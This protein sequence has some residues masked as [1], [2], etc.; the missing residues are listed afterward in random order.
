MLTRLRPN[1]KI[2]IFIFALIFFVIAGSFVN[3]QSVMTNGLIANHYDKGDYDLN[4]LANLAVIAAKFIWGISG[5]LALLAFVV[6]GVMWLISS[7]NPQMV[8]KGRQT[9][10]GAVIGLAIVFGSYVIIN[11]I[12]VKVFDISNFQFNSN[13]FQNGVTNSSANPTNP[14]TR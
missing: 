2:Y 12:L 14:T 11:F 10:I 13:W 3:A 1:R 5:S 8:E 9:I 4:D 7:G 6:G